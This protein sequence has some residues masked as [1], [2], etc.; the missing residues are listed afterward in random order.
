MLFGLMETLGLTHTGTALDS[1]RG[2]TMT[3]KDTVVKNDRWGTGVGCHH[4]G[5][6]TCADR[7]NPGHLVNHKWENCMTIDF[8][9]WGYRRNAQLNSYATIEQLL[10]T[11]AET[12]SCGG[13]LLMNVGPTHDGRIV[14]IFEERLRQMGE[15]LG[16]NGEAIYSSVPWVHQ[17]DTTTPGVW[18]TSKEDTVY[19]VVLS[20]PED[21][22]LTLGAVNTQASTK[23]TLMGYTGDPFKWTAKQGAGIIIEF[24]AIPSNH[25]PCKWAWVLELQ[26][27][28]PSGGSTLKW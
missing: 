18:Y 14:P 20:W 27:V 22:T 12:V 24:P 7:Y 5:Y 1:L 15:W 25:M 10:T 13:N 21:G 17:N 4:G 8:S 6:Y 2:F 9:S 28:T 3:V 11:L 23:I 19:A 26:N 16:V